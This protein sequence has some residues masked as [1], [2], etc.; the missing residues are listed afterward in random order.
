M[1]NKTQVTHPDSDHRGGTHQAA[2]LPPAPPGALTRWAE[3]HW[4]LHRAHRPRQSSGGGG[5]EWG[6]SSSPAPDVPCTPPHER[7]CQP[8]CPASQEPEPR[9]GSY[10]RARPGSSELRKFWDPGFCLPASSSPGHS[11]SPRALSVDT[12]FPPDGGNQDTSLL[13]TYYL[14]T[15]Q[16]ASISVSLSNTCMLWR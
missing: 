3:G 1:E 7:L 12:S 8:T 9:K 4:S 13:S 14:G 5:L 2:Q 16:V 6:P 10:S 11:S 15:L